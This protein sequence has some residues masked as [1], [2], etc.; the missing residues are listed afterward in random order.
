M[1]T[2]DA[3]LD[4]ADQHVEYSH[5]NHKTMQFYHDDG[6]EHMRMVSPKRFSAL[7]VG[8]ELGVIY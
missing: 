3:G 4:P 6:H 7:P 1:A 8:D 5:L 2:L